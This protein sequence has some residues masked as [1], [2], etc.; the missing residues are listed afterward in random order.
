MYSLSLYRVAYK[1]FSIVQVLHVPRH[2][3]SLS[4]A[5]DA[6]CFHPGQKLRLNELNSS[7]FFYE[8]RVKC[9]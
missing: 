5:E 2:S 4:R 6:G 9:V 3:Q 1:G 7:V 8:A